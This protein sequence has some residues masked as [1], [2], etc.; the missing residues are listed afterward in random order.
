MAHFDTNRVTK[1]AFKPIAKTVLNYN[2][3]CGDDVG[4]KQSNASLSA[5]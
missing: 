5:L 3:D 1:H 2:G 4:E